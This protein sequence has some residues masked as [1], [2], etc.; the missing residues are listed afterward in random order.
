MPLQTSGPISLNEIH[1]E[2]GGT[3]GTTVSI[4]DA[5]IRGLISKASG[6]LM[7]FSEWYGASA[8]TYWDTTMTV[9][10]FQ[11]KDFPPIYGYALGVYGSLADNTVDNMNDEICSLLNWNDGND[12]LT[13]IVDTTDV[14]D[15]RGNTEFTT[16]TIGG[17]DFSNSSATYTFTSETNRS[18][19]WSS[20]TNPFGTTSGATRSIVMS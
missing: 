4:N 12:S 19:E 16:L 1:I 15:V 9:G 17:V 13:L 5:D 20:V 18:W 3:T 2:A 8:L 14:T 11:I 10:V 7:S 6:A